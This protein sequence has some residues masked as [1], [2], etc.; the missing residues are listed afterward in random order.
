M[1]L[2]AKHIVATVKHAK[3][4]FQVH[5][6]RLSG[7]APLKAVAKLEIGRSICLLRKQ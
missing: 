3:L 7:G 6:S 4:F 2:A 1:E 5:L